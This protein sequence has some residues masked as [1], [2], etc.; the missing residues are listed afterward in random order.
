MTALLIVRAEVVSPEDIPKFDHW[1]RTEHLPE[2]KQKFMALRAWRGFSDVEPHIHYA[3]YE[4]ADLDAVR[5]AT[6]SVQ[7]AELIAEFDRT[8]EG[9]VTRSRDRVEQIQVL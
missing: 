6:S 5:V 8:W 9:R 7:I 4:F 3:F 1:Y 2:A